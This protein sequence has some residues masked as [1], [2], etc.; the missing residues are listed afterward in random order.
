MLNQW[1]LI[2]IIQI[3]KGTTYYAQTT[4]TGSGS[5]IIDFSKSKFESL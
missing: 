2:N 3:Y 1:F 5:R 4:V